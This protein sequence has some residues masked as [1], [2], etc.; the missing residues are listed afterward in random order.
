MLLP[1]TDFSRNMVNQQHARL[2]ETIPL[3]DPLCCS[4]PKRLYG[5]IEAKSSA[6][7][8]EKR[9]LDQT[10]HVTSCSGRR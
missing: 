7:V 4:T 3:I 6:R 2:D 5:Y 1:T 8:D 9:F 10:H